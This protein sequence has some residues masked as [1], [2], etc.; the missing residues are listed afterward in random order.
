MLCYTFHSDLA[1]R[2]LLTGLKIRRW[3]QVVDA[4][5]S[6]GWLIVYHPWPVLLGA[7]LRALPINVVYRRAAAYLQL[8]AHEVLVRNQELE[9]DLGYLPLRLVGVERAVRADVRLERLLQE[10]KEK[11]HVM[12]CCLFASCSNGNNS[13]SGNRGGTPRAD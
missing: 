3:L 10:E 6:G 5:D 11:L 7:D 2:L 4:D 12:Y 1:V 8:A 9:A 13:S